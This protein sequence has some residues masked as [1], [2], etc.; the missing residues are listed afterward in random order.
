[1]HSLPTHILSYLLSNSNLSEAN[2]LFETQ[3]NQRLFFF[4]QNEAVNITSPNEHRYEVEHGVPSEEGGEVRKL[5][6]SKVNKLP[7]NLKESN[8]LDFHENNSV[9]NDNDSGY[10]EAVHIEGIKYESEIKNSSSKNA[11]KKKMEK[12]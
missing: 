5:H 9:K 12:S 4:H 3:L 2:Q 1:M 6:H 10:Q 8:R 7:D 11:Q